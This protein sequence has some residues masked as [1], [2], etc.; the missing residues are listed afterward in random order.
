MCFQIHELTFVML[1]F[2]TQICPPQVYRGVTHDSP[3]NL[4]PSKGQLS[5]LPHLQLCPECLLGVFLFQEWPEPL[6]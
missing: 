5:F 6:W 3:Q 4:L 2:R 1:V